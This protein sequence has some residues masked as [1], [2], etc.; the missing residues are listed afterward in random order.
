ML[1]V[2]SDGCTF[3]YV[4]RGNR[5]YALCA[6]ADRVEEVLDKA[7]LLRLGSIGDGLA[8]ELVGGIVA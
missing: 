3:E 8:G 5:G 7:V 4:N 1:D 6:V 2:S